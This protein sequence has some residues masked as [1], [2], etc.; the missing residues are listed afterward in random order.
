MEWMEDR[1]DWK[2][3][4]SIVTLLVPYFVLHTSNV[5]LFF[6]RR[7]FNRCNK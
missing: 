2:K 7:V 1:K 3:Q 5:S 6:D 4:R